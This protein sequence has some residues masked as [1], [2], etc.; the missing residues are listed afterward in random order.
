MPA[1]RSRPGRWWGVAAGVAAAQAAVLA[2]AVAAGWIALGNAPLVLVLFAGATLAALYPLARGLDSTAAWLDAAGAAGAAGAAPPPVP[3]PGP[4]AGALGALT[5]RIRVLLERRDS[6]IDALR[7]EAGR[8][9]D[10]LPDPL[11]LLAR[12]RR[13]LRL[14]GAGRRLFGEEA[15]G[16]DLSHVLRDPALAAAVDGVLRDGAPRAEEI[17]F[18]VEQVARVYAVDIAPLPAVGHGG[19]AVMVALRDV[20]AVRRTERMRV[21]FV[22]NASHEIRS[23]LAT[24]IG[25]IETLRGPARDDPEARDRFLT[26]MHDQGRRMARLVGDLLSLS[27]IELEEHARPTGEVDIGG[28]L[29]RIRASL[30]PEAEERAMTLEVAVPADLPEVR[31]SESE[32]EQVGYN[33]IS[34]AIKY[35]R[36]GSRVSVVTRRHDTPPPKLRMASGAVVSVTVSDRGQ[37][38]APRH[39]PRLTER[40]YRADTARSRE[41]GGT[42]LGL[43]IVKHIL[44]HHRGELEIASRLGEGSSFTV[45]LPAPRHRPGRAAGRPADPPVVHADT[46]ERHATVTKPS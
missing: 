31:G 37:G 43:A 39:L 28:L 21:D 46:A 35:G 1:F 44:N 6:E 32:L 45:W 25:G 15:G 8:L 10:A 36:R 41:L 34:N 7:A 42:G 30:A 24:L 12:D 3:K 38:I 16:R 33:L 17:A 13:V 26:M 22:A 23:P 18:A 4:G 19:P 11:L 14:N 29:R 2:V 5:A 40:F 9:L 20:T 27:R